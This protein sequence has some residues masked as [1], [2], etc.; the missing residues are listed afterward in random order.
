MK[1][2]FLTMI[3]AL[4]CMSM[5]ATPG[6]DKK[7]ALKAA[8]TRADHV[9]QTEALMAALCADGFGLD[10]EEYELLM[11][12]EFDMLDDLAGS[13]TMPSCAGNAPDL[14]KKVRDWDE[15]IPR[16]V[17]G[18]PH[19][20][21]DLTISGSSPLDGMIKGNVRPG[22]QPTIGGGRPGGLDNPIDVIRPN[23]W[24]SG[25][26]TDGGTGGNNGSSGGSSFEDMIKGTV[27]P[28]SQPTIGGSR[29]TKPVIPIVRVDS[30]DGL[31]G[32]DDNVKGSVG[33]GKSNGDFPDVAPGGGNGNGSGD[34]GVDGSRPTRPIGPGPIDF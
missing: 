9:T 14:Q 3:G 6:V 7:D 17:P 4:T 12:Q 5:M 25:D 34:E 33:D 30:C 22:S 8:G 10:A 31:N 32:I 20:V 24:Q 16:P 11:G 27:R 21:T 18:F 13:I 1:K 28:G 29:P 26:E 2:I 19:V 23:S 15:P